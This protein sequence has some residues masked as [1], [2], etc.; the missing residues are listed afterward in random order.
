MPKLLDTGELA[1]RL[2][3]GANTLEKWR[4]TGDGPPFIRLNRRTIR[5]DEGD[6]ETWLSARR[7][8]STSDQKAA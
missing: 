2:G 8:K 6:V 5:Y 7:A 1:G 4:L 3:L